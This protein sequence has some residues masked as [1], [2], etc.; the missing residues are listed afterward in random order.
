MLLR[1]RG[2]PTLP[3]LAAVVLAVSLPAAA[4][5]SATGAAARSASAQDED[6]IWGQVRTVEGKEYSG[7]IVWAGRGPHDAANWAD[8]LEA[9]RFVA[10]AVYDAWLAATGGT[11]PVRIIEVEGH[12]VS[13]NEEDPE[14]PSTSPAAV[15]FGRLAEVL[16]TGDGQVEMTLRSP[17]G[18][19]E[20]PVFRFRRPL[21]NRKALTVFDPGAGEEDI[22][23]GDLLRVEFSS[24]PADARASSRRLHGTVEDRFGRSYTGYVAWDSDEILDSEVLDGTDEQGDDTDLLFGD[25]RRIEQRRNEAR[26]TL[27]SGRELVLSGTNDVDRRNRG[28]RVFDAALGMV[29]VEWDEFDVLRLEPPVN[30]V[31]YAEFHDSWRLAGTVVTQEGDTIAGRL[32]WDAEHEWSWELLHGESRGV[33]FAIEFGAVAKIERELE[34]AVVTLVGGR[35]LEL[36]GSGDVDWDNRGIFVAPSAEPGG[37][38][39]SW[40]YVDWNDF[41]EV[42]FV[43]DATPGKNGGASR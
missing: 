30:P 39:G 24:P 22:R 34:G 6:R 15:R 10:P 29:E 27:A 31:R 1:R 12:R 18:G 21:R 32:R 37:N 25:V 38:P 3:L 42:R 35:V 26:I 43:R 8:F 36:A 33:K 40:R 28:V 14:F 41:R 17:D 20:R 13:W 2:S 4:Q 23:W 11:R 7:F 19:S 16:V 9:D 5:E